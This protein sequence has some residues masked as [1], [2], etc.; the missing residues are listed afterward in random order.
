M[1]GKLCRGLGPQLVASAHVDLLDL[2]SVWGHVGGVNR[3]PHGRH[4]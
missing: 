1:L 3:L 4:P 2:A